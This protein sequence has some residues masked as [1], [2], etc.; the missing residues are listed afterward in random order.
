MD[1]STMLR[2]E[3]ISVSFGSTVV[4]EDVQFAVS[5]GIATGLVG[6]N[7]AGKTTLFNVATGFVA[8]GKGTVNFLGRD[9]TRTPAP[10]RARLG[11]RRTFQEVRL[12]R[13][14]TALENVVLGFPQ[15]PSE[16]V[17][18]A[19]LRIG[20]GRRFE[21]A[22]RESAMSLLEQVGVPQLASNY[23]SEMSYGQQKRV[24]LARAMAGDVELL[25][26]DEPAAG[27]DARA[28]ENMVAL[29]RGLISN[30][31]TLLL[32]EHDLRLVE[33]LCD[34]CLFMDRGRGV[35]EGTPQDV[36]ADTRVKKAFAG[37]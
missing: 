3:G 15:H 26:L 29:L 8:C 19:V 5:R 1:D 4:L 7:G 9:V 34:R 10:K 36:L 30:G 21:R 17:V 37:L 12:F 24:A 16:T 20:K 33:Q 23:P 35:L 6:P 32:V 11:L 22:V 18:G 27:L 2:L 28:K 13:E 31:V 25:C 14:M